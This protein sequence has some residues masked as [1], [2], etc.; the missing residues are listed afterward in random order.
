[1]SFPGLDD[2]ERRIEELKQEGNVS[3]FNR[4]R[5]EKPGEDIGPEYHTI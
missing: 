1:M 4:R 5:T 2:I 3:L